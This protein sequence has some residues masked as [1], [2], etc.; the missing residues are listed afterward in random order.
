MKKRIMAL[1]L[2]LLLIPC[3]AW[4]EELTPMEI[5]CNR[6]RDALTLLAAGE[7]ELALELIGFVFDVESG[8]TEETF[9]EAVGQLTLL[10]AELLQTEVALCWLDAETG[11]WHLGIPLVEPV[12]WDVE[13]LVLDS[14]DLEVFCGYSVTDW[15]TLEEAALFSEEA[16]WNVEYVPGAMMLLADE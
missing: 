10:D 7:T 6:G 11:V 3:A 15:E 14:R 12:S 5:F 1:L 8:L 4:A 16:Y 2:S 9:V 13:V